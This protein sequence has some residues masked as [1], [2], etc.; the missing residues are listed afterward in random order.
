MQYYSICNN[1]L[2]LAANGA[3]TVKNVFDSSIL[4]LDPL[5]IIFYN[6]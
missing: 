5:E 1:G 2:I 6:C 3:I 4:C